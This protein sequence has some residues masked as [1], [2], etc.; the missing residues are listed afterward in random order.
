MAIK[1]PELGVL[2]RE[3]GYI[4]NKSRG[5]HRES[6]PVWTK[7]SLHTDSKTQHKA[8]K[9]IVNGKS[10]QVHRLVAE[11]FIP[12]PE[13]KPTVD[14]INRDSTDNRVSNLRWA[15]MKEQVEN[16]GKV[17]NRTDY[18]V[19]SCE[20][21]VEYHKQWYK[22]RG[23]QIRN[24]DKERENNKR[25]RDSHPGLNAERCRKYH[26]EHRDEINAK[27]RLDYAAKRQGTI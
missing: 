7:G 2:V 5:N 1:H 15:T 16:S 13:H 23:K 11:C 6:Q 25:Y 26:D 24:K 18:G 10:N 3:D 9:V 17:L 27:R 20:D 19:R 14:H 21:A 4:F 8:Y 22:K 12:N